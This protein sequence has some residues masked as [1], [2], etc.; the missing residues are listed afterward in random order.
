VK[1]RRSRRVA[2]R[3]GNGG[4]AHELGHSLSLGD[5]GDPWWTLMNTGFYAFPHATF[6][7]DQKNTLVTSPF[8]NQTALLVNGGFENACTTGWTL[9]Y[10]QPSCVTGSPDETTLVRSGG[11]TLKLG[12]GTFVLH[13][14]VPVQAGKAYG[15]S[16]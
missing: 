1:R 10:G 15:F 7:A 4:V 8:F 6:N 13:E 5:G 9:D 14:T 3:G 16:G 2:L 12:A 11:S